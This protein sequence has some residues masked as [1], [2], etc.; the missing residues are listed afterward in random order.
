MRRTKVYVAGPY[1]AGDPVINTARAIDAGTA[2]LERGY[3]PFVPHLTMFWH[4]KD[5]QKYETWLA[6]D[7]EWVASC[8]V[9]LRLPGPSSG[10]DR[11]V[12]L[13]NKLG[14]RVEYSLDVLVASV[15]PTRE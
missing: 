2:L 11:E 6:Y 1:T 13:A 5:P 4:M 14:I 9:L 8:D 10:A 3:A 15:P 12:E 7:F